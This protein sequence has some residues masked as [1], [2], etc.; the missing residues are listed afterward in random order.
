MLSMKMEK[1][2]FWPYEEMQLSRW[3]ADGTAPLV[4]KGRRKSEQAG[5]W[6]EN[7]E[8]FLWV[9]LS[10]LTDLPEWSDCE[11]RLVG[12]VLTAGVSLLLDKIICGGE[13]VV[14]FG[15]GRECVCACTLCSVCLIKSLLN[16]TWVLHCV[17][18]K[19]HKQRGGFEWH[20]VLHMV[21]LKSTVKVH[22]LSPKSCAHMLH[23]TKFLFFFVLFSFLSRPY[24]CCPL[25][26]LRRC[27]ILSFLSL[28]T[29]DGTTTSQSNHQ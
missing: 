28:M 4:T 24:W 11:N 17:H 27:V 20:T 2:A 15:C 6:E 23:P 5:H 22:S 9:L 8:I 3:P 21:T 26:L 10:W 12:S 25:P 14:S 29:L 13:K 7:K 19:R 16:R 18:V 1:S